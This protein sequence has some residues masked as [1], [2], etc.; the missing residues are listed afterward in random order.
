[1][2]KNTIIWLIVATILVLSGLI[3]FAS[4]L[5]AYDWDFDNLS[6]ENYKTSTHENLSEEFTD[7][8]IDTDTADII[9]VPSTD[10]KVKVECYESEKEKHE[11]YV[12]DNTLTINVKND[13][14]WYNYIGINLSFNSPKITVYLPQR[15]YNALVIKESTGDVELPNDFTF[16]S[17]DIISS[18]GDIKCQAAAKSDVSIRTS[19]GDIDLQ[20]V[21]AESFDLST[22]TGEIF[23]SKITCQNN[24]DVKVSTGDVN[25]NSVNCQNFTS[26]GS[27]GDIKMDG[28]VATQNFTIVRSTGYVL[29]NGCDGGEINIQTDTGDING[30]LLSEKIFLTS[31]DTGSVNVPNTTT[32]GKCQITTDTG[33]IHITIK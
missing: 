30:S 16:Q 4:A 25:L 33:D 18:T 8:S 14:E 20:N 32:G 28:V 9:F 27:T 7:I 3:V 24:F 15:E 29:L 10:G 21:F 1:M 11:V 26:T 22:S 19:T 23:A 31:T 17:I 13:K 12:Q 6:T 2:S 5:T